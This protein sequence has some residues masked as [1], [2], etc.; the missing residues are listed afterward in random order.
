MGKNQT[1]FKKGQIANPTGRPKRKWTWSG[2][3][4]KYADMKDEDGNGKVK[5][6]VVKRVMQL[7]ERGDMTAVKEIFNRMDGMPR[8][9]TKVSIINPQPLL[10]ALHNNNR[11]QKAK[12]TKEEN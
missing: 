7:A 8:Q 4:E 2:L 10:D 9:N 1:S 6:A 3:L 11:S 5:D 12:Q